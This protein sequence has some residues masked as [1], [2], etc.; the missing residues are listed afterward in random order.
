MAGP[1][2][3]MREALDA[4]ECWAL[5]ERIAASTQLRRAS[6]LQELLYYL[7]KRSLKDH[8]ESVHE[9]TVGVEVFGRSEGYDTSADNIV[10]TSVSELRKRIDAYFSAEG[11]GEALTMEIPRWNYVPVFK[12]RPVHVPALPEFPASVEPL[13]VEASKALG[14]PQAD[15]HPNQ[16]PRF[17]LIATAIVAVLLGLG[18]LFFWS[19]YRIASARY[20][21]LHRSLYA[22]QYEPSVAGLWAPILSAKP[23]TDIV[24]ADASFGLLQDINK[25]SF[26]FYDYLSH[27]YVNEIQKRP[28]SPD[29]H[30]VL[31]RIAVWNLGSPDEFMLARRILA[32]DPLGQ[33]IHVY[34]ARNYMPV[35]T[36]RDN[37]ILIGG[38]IS[39]PW[40]DLF[41]SQMNF[42]IKFLANESIMVVNRAPTAGEPSFYP[43]T[44]SVQYCVVS[45]LPNPDHNGVVMLIEG[46]DAEAT[47]AAGDFLMSDD[48]LSSFKKLMHVDKFPYFEVLLKVSSVPGTPL[49]ASVEAYRT[50]PYLH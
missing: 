11:A 6:R 31:N 38:R 19:Q 13:P 35:L 42:T 45:Y 41:E 30:A 32:L 49:T 1:A 2:I 21:S 29:L 9:Q 14:E 20:E 10:R 16:A 24:L 8:C 36:K 12:H 3:Q 43:Q 26:S 17:A 48:Q 40:D 33:S 50:Y 27:S 5:L 7:G 47:E 46:T 22:W 4:E 25:K 28:L 34:S 18:C 23:D 37:V 39:N 44:D 15:A